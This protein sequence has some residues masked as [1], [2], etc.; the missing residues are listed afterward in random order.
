MTAKADKKTRTNDDQAKR[1]AERYEDIKSR[2]EQRA[3]RVS[4]AGRDIGPPPAIVDPARRDGT[5]SDFRA[6]CETYAAESFPLAWSPDHLTAEL[7]PPRRR[8]QWT[9]NAFYCID[10]EVAA[11]KGTRTLEFSLD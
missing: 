1:D 9:R 4:A 10:K 2:D 11:L 8:R 5:R 6:F 3:R 7:P